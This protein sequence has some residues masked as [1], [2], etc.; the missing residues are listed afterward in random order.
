MTGA[1]EQ[2]YV[3][4]G[5]DILFDRKKRNGLRPDAAAQLGAIA[6][7]V[8]ADSAQQIAIARPQGNQITTAPMIGPENDPFRGQLREGG[9]DIAGRERRAIGAD[10]DDLLITKV[11]DFLDRRFE[12]LGES[13]TPLRVGVEA[14]PAHGEFSR[15][16]KVHVRCLHRSAEPAEGKERP[17]E[18]GQ[19]ASGK[20][21]PDRVGK[22]E[23][24]LLFHKGSDSVTPLLI[25]L[26]MQNGEIFLVTCHKRRGRAPAGEAK[27][28]RGVARQPRP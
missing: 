14:R 17:E 25:P 27:S 16:E 18:T 13:P 4:P 5:I 10:E 28:Q 20:I 8:P 3:R 9:G 24:G 1:R 7:A 6:I 19:A 22:N 15:G 23:K 26:Q 2:A 21:E 11:R 12:P